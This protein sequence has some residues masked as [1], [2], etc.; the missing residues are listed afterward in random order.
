MGKVIGIDLGTTNSCVAVMEAGKAEIIINSEGKRTTPSVISF[1]DGDRSVGDPAKRQSVTNPTNTVYSV[2]RF[3]GSKYSEISKEAN[4]MAYKVMKGKGGTVIVKID[5]KD[6]IPQEISAVILQNLKKTAEDYLGEDVTQAVITVP[7]Y[8]NDEQRKATK[9]AGEIAGLEVL[10]II[11]EPTAAA[12][13]YGLNDKEEKTI[14][15]YDLGG[16]TFDISILEIGDGVFEVLSTNG[17]THL[18]GDNFDEVIVDWLLD[19]F[20][21][22]NNMDLSSDPAALQRLRE[23]AEKAKVELSNSKQTEINLP[24]ITADGTGPKHLVKT[25][26]RAKF[27]S[28]VDGLVKKSL[29]PVRKALKDAKLKVTD[30]D[31]VLLVGGSTRI[32]VIQEAVKKLFKKEPSKGVNPDE[33]VAMGAAIQGGVLAGEVNDVLLLDVTPLSLGI[34]TMGGIMTKLIESN[35]TI[36]TTKSQTF[37]TAV[38]NQPSVDIHILQGERPVIDGNRTLGRFQLTDLPPAQRGIPQIEVTFD[39]DANGIIKVSAKDKG[40]GKEQ[41]IKIESGSSLS[42]EEIERMKQEAEANVDADNEKL[43]KTQKLNECDSMIFQTEKQLK[44]YDEKLEDTDKSR[45][46]NDIKDLKELRE[47]E[48]MEGIDDMMEKMNETWQEISAKLYEETTPEGEEPINEGPENQST[49]VEF[50]EVK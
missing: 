37:S 45:L 38:D 1:K 42:E 15:V 35:T 24:Y 40:T 11:N 16:G 26:S 13:A 5:D 39:I 33:V 14:A 31:E 12:L 8:F 27:E 50:E 46:E 32:P 36:P 47:Q 44:D 19:E 20:K 10:R 30:I 41:D 2:K 22:E 18:G 23:G 6:Y 29:A 25:L 7:A 49:D 28:M 21:S 34:E 17:D 4:K 9:E 3:I 43:E 48:D